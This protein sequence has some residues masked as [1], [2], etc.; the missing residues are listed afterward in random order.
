MRKP[1]STVELDPPSGE[2]EPH[3][4]RGYYHGA[5]A[6]VEALKEGIPLDE[7]EAFVGAELRAWR[8]DHET[9]AFPPEPDKSHLI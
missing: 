2:H 9:P 6:M 8:Q 7:L 1:P 4:R 5:Y 3:F